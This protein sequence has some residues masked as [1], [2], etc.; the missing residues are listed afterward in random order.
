MLTQDYAKILRGLPE[1]LTRGGTVL[2]CVNDPAIGPEFLIEGMAEQAPG[3]AFVERLEN[4]PEFPDAD[5]AGGLKAL[6]FRQ[7]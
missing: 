2:A 1:L 5:P 4:P 7:A 3:L 6:V